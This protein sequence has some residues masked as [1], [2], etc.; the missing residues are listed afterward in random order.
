MEPTKV[1]FVGEVC[2]VCLESVLIFDVVLTTEKDMKANEKLN[3]NWSRAVP[4]KEPK[5][6]TVAHVDIS[7]I[8]QDISVNA[9]QVKALLTLENGY[10]HPKQFT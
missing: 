9:D 6:K 3:T 7:D 4:Q 1:G 10:M 2:F 5:T 8:I